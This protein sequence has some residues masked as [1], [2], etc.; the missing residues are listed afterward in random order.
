MGRTAT[1]PVTA[2][3][4]ATAFTS[5]GAACAKPDSTA[6]AVRSANVFL[7]CTAS[8]V[9]FLVSAILS[10]HRGQSGGALVSLRH[11]PC[12]PSP[13][14]VD[15]IDRSG[16]SREIRFLGISPLEGHSLLCLSLQLPP[17]LWRMLLQ[18]RMGRPLLQRD[19]SSW[20]PRPQ[21]PGSLPVPERGH[22]RWRDGALQLPTWLYSEY[23]L[24][25]GGGHFLGLSWTP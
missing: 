11:R 22:L 17:H 14:R 7:G 12:L 18:G 10:T 5:A 4:G 13:H 9:S 15:G 2:P 23:L 20:I 1:R 3:T 19:V 16:P 6:V 21:V 24:E 8:A 25:A